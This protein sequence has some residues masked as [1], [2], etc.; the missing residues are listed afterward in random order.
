MALTVAFWGAWTWI[1]FLIWTGRVEGDKSTARLVA[2]VSAV[3]L[4][5]LLATIQKKADRA[6]RMFSGRGYDA[7]SRPGLAAALAGWAIQVVPVGILY[8]T[9]G[10]P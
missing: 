9:V 8:Y 6:W 1:F 3:I 10:S 5:L 7:L 2:R 4:Y